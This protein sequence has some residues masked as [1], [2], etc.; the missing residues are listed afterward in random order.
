[1]IP[2]V[3]MTMPKIKNEAFLDIAVLNIFIIPVVKIIDFT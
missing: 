1:M 2:K 3:K